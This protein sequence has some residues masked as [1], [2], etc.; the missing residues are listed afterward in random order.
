[1]QAT[2]WHP[3]EQR[4]CE[5]IISVVVAKIGW[6]EADA[7]WKLKIPSLSVS[8]LQIGA[9]ELNVC[10]LLICQ[11]CNPSQLAAQNLFDDSFASRLLVWCD[12]IEK[13][14]HRWDQE[15]SDT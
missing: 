2:L 8:S 13:S 4:A 7:L 14:N 1:M 12:W 10:S 5:C 3:P 9:W 6:V 15:D 11:E